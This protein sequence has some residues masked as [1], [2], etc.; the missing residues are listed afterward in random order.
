M[1]LTFKKR[2]SLTYS[3]LLA[4]LFKVSPSS[5]L[6]SRVRSNIWLPKARKVFSKCLRR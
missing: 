6:F 2:S 1:E 5:R 3:R 4:F